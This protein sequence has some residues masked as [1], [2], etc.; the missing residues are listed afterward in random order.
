VGFYTRL[1]IIASNLLAAAGALGYGQ[2]NI[3]ALPTALATAVSTDHKWLGVTSLLYCANFVVAWRFRNVWT[4]SSTRML[5]WGVIAYLGI[6]HLVDLV[7]LNWD[8]ISEIL[9]GGNENPFAIGVR[10]RISAAAVVITMAV[11]CI[12]VGFESRG[13]T[14]I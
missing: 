1:T 10:A 11:T 7:G 13:E 8:S 5:V 6:S 14:D 3:S 9:F 4:V 12:A 2:A